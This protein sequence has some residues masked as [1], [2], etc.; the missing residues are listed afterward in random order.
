MSGSIESATQ[1]WVS[2]SHGM[3]VVVVAILKGQTDGLL[4]FQLGE[5]TKVVALGVTG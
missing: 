4:L 3:V 5:K 1:T 2:T